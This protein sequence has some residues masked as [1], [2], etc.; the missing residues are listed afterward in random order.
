MVDVDFS[1]VFHVDVP[2][3]CKAVPKRTDIKAPFELL[4]ATLHGDPAEYA[5]ACPVG[6]KLFMSATSNVE[7]PFE[8]RLEA[9]SGWK[10]KK[11]SGQTSKSNADGTW[12]KHFHDTLT[13]PV[14]MPANPSSGGGATG[15]DDNISQFG[16]VPKPEEPIGPAGIPAGPGQV[17]TGFNQ[18]NF[19]EDSVRLVVIGGGK[20]IKTDW[21]KYKVTC[22]PKKN[23][24]VAD[25]PDSVGQSVFIEQAA[26]TLSP[27]APKDGSKCGVWASGYIQTN[28]KNVNVTFRLKN[29]QGNTTNSQTIKTTHANNIGKFVEYLDFSKSGEGIWESQGGGWALP[30]AGAGSQAGQKTGTLQIVVEN[31]AKFEGNVS[32]YDFTCYDPAPVGYQ[33][34]PTVKVDPEILQGP[35]SVVGNDKPTTAKPGTQIVPPVP[36][37]GCLGGKVRGGKCICDGK[38]VVIGGIIS[39]KPTKF[40]C[41]AEPAKP[42]VTASQISCSGGKVSKGKCGAARA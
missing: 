23:P 34:V 7:G 3:V 16:T 31:P 17:Q 1:H 41:E 12:S 10:S 11:Y 37:I 38:T 29:H 18:P 42:D 20:T 15:S 14:V 24:A 6:I 2:V 13:V 22:D 8:A 4:S 9:K 21:W 32:S 33:T 30:G 5:G 25:T 28:V 26:L 39:G 40:R 19:H 35:N 36:P 27:V